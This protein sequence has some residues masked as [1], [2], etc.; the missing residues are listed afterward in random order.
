[1]YWYIAGAQA[2][3][4]RLGCRGRDAFHGV[5]VPKD[6]VRKIESYRV[7][8]LLSHGGY[9]QGRAEEELGIDGERG[10]VVGVVHPGRMLA[11]G[12]A[13]R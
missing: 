1:M 11:D 5:K 2:G 8:I 6:V 13:K 10:R 4:R 9:Q 7:R 3:V 12:G